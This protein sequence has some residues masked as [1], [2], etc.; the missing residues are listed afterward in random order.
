MSPS[1][2]IPLFWHNGIRVSKQ[3]GMFYT[4]TSEKRGIY[5][6]CRYIVAHI[7]IN[8]VF[9]A[10]RE[11]L[12]VRITVYCY[13]RKENRKRRNLKKN[14]GKEMRSIYTIRVINVSYPTTQNAIKRKFES[15]NI[16]Y[17]ALLWLVVKHVLFLLFVYKNIIQNSRALGVF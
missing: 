10:Q 6:C 4:T 11:A 17:A 3:L 8:L 14:K 5:F 2:K 12:K 7:H 1:F 9:Y 15:E 13:N 16:R